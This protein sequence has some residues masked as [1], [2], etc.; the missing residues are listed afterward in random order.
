MTSIFL[1]STVPPKSSTAIFTASTAP[2][3]LKLV[4]YT[5]DMSPSTPIFTTSFEIPAADALPPA[6]RS[7]MPQTVA[8][9]DDFMIFLPVFAS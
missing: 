6:A 8:I 4:E 2:W 1:P 7:A 5:P 9:Y 3:P